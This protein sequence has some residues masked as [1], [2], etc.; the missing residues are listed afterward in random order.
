M[1]KEK[2]TVEAILKK[3]QRVLYR[4]YR[5]YHGALFHFLNRQIQS[6]ETCEEL[7]QDVFLEF[8][9]GLRG[10]RGEASLKTYLFTIARYKAIDYMK[11]KKLKKVLFSALPAGVVEGLVKIFMDDTIE[12][13]E[14]AAKIERTI[15]R[16][17]NDYQVILRLKYIDG[18][19]VK[20][21][22]ARMALPFK[23]T[24]SLLFRARMAFIRTY[25]SLT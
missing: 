25:Q 3:D 13:K 1:E 19:R 7:V 17:P 21:I 15:G 6:R 2:K 5:Q 14:L 23:A 18:R 10:Y 11:K 20:E 24:E 16:L 12:Q 22:A 9:E 8:I 4:F